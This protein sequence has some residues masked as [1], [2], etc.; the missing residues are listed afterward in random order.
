MHLPLQV[1]ED[2]FFARAA[3]SWK[4]SNKITRWSVGCDAIVCNS[5]RLMFCPI[6]TEIMIT[7]A[8]FNFLAGPSTP[9]L[10]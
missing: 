4:L 9:P 6:P 8:S 7:P 1:L 10:L 3:S 2:I 5:S